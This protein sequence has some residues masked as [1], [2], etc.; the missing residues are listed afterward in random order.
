MADFKKAWDLE[1]RELFEEAAQYRGDVA[2]PVYEL[3]MNSKNALAVAEA[4]ERLGDNITKAS[5]ELVAGITA[6]AAIIADAGEAQEHYARN[7][8]F[9]T[10]ALVGATLALV[11]VAVWQG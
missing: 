8:M 11:G 7:L 4:T 10:W 6:A 2:F 5:G 1:P 3:A 9:A